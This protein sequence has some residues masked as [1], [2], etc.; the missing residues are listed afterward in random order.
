MKENCVCDFMSMFD[1]MC[2]GVCV[3][4]HICTHCRCT[5]ANDS[6]S[7]CCRLDQ[8]LSASSIVSR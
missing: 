3:S 4:V 1:V 5:A 8:T 6:L 7:F 2:V